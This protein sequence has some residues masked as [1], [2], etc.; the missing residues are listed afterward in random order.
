M[1]L[2]TSL[3]WS[4]VS[5]SCQPPGGAT[6][7]PLHSVVH[8]QASRAS[9]RNSSTLASRST[10]APGTNDTRSDRAANP[11]LDMWYC[12]PLFAKTRYGASTTHVVG[13][14]DLESLRTPW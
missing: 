14:A 5:W 10:A 4:G 7:V 2:E 11:Q 3:L 13:G 8:T 12:G 6:I 1:A 9:N